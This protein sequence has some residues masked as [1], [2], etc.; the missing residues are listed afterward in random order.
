MA[1]DDAGDAPVSTTV[2][3]TLQEWLDEEAQ[4]L[5]VS[6]AE[7]IRR[8]LGAYQTVTNGD[9]EATAVD[10]LFETN[11]V[12]ADELETRL[13]SVE[14]AQT[15]L[16]ADFQGKIEDVRER[17]IQIKRETDAKADAEHDHPELRQQTERATER[18]AQV[19]GEMQTLQAQFA[20]LRGDLDA[21]FENYEDVLEYLNDATEDLEAKLT[22]LAQAVL[23][24]RKSTA[25]QAARESARRAV[26]ELAHEAQKRAIRSANCE[27]CGRRVDIALLSRPECPHCVSP[28]DGVEEGR[29]FRP[30]TLTVGDVPALEG[31]DRDLDGQLEAILEEEAER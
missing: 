19:T 9:G 15:E 18:L 12:A 17:V 10:E 23:E 1:S 24:V 11:G 21:G 25:T 28:F 14:R 30:A 31:S 26:D 29:W 20:D 3:E 6:R 2:E 4:Q 13:T 22:V 27:E 7:L 5:G 8:V 16:D